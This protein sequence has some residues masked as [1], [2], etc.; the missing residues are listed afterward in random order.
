M[1]THPT[2]QALVEGV[3]AWL[4]LDG[5]ASPFALRVARNALD[6]AARDMAPGPA[7]DERAACRIAAILGRDDGPRDELDRA[8]VTAIRAGTI[9]PDDPQLVAHLAASALDHLAIDQPRY[10]HELD[11]NLTKR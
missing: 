6:I 1:L 10:L 2:A 11:P 4:P 8:L 9:A 3:A 5:S 7:A